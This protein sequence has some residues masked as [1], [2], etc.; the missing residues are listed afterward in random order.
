MIDP[1]LEGHYNV[2]AAI[3]DHADYF[4]RWVKQSDDWRRRADA[5]FDAQYGDG[6]NERI[7][8]YKPG[9]P[10][11]PVH[12]FIH[13]GYWQARTKEEFAFLS[14]SLVNAG[15]LVAMVEYE[16]CPTVTLETIVDQMRRALGWLYHNAV[17]FGGN[18][19]RIHISGHSAGGHLTA[20]MMATDW[21]AM[22][23]TLPQDLVKS[24]VSISGLFDLE[25]LCHTS[26][27]D[28]VGLDVQTAK[29]LSPAFMNPVSSGPLAL[30]VGGAESEAFHA[31]SALI[32]KNWGAAGTKLSRLNL[33]GCNHLSA[34]QQ[35][36]DPKSELF[37][38]A[39]SFLNV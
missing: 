4:E 7:D 2:R 15:A 27:N 23:E 38:V 3:P 21:Q 26:I 28:A 24:G 20:M 37:S 14:E 22:D 18:A 8:L 25:P 39:S 17:E 34:V 1:V 35:L 29:R 30:A 19:N 33:A 9:N 12:M 13:G 5:K 11:A 6:A 10:N 16:L 31:Q 36:A 32:E